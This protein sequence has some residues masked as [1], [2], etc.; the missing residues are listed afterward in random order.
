MEIKRRI[1]YGSRKYV[2]RATLGKRAIVEA[3][4]LNGGGLKKAQLCA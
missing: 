1:K 3:P 2:L 4:E